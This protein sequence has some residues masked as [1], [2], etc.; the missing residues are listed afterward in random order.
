MLYLSLI[1]SICRLRFSLVKANR[2]AATRCW[3]RDPLSHPVIAAMSPTELADLPFPAY[4]LPDDGADERAG[5][6]HATPDR[7]P[8]Q[9]SASS[10]AKPCI[11]AVA[12]L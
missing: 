12:R 6:T 8:V 5:Q 11:G 1:K 2:D 7:K 3:A 10:R 9:A 4:R